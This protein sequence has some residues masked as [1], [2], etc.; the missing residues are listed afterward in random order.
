MTFLRSLARKKTEEYN[1]H[2]I[3]CACL[4]VRACVR[5]CVCFIFWTFGINPCVY[6][7]E[8]VC[9]FI[10][11]AIPLSLSSAPPCFLFLILLTCNTHTLT[12]TQTHKDTIFHHVYIVCR[13]DL[14]IISLFYVSSSV[15]L[16]KK[17]SCFFL[18][19]VFF[20]YASSSFIPPTHPSLPILCLCVRVRVICVYVFCNCAIFPPAPQHLLVLNM[21]VIPDS[22]FY[23]NF[24]NKR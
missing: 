10:L 8:S 24:Q 16:L 1:C 5:V 6:G 18:S 14:L 11:K 7:T 2:L 21:T 4:Y 19:S 9:D 17:G 15:F 22:L 23:W 3:Y 13:M 12:H 20:K